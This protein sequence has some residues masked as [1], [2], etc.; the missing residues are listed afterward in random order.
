MKIENAKMWK[1]NN[2]INHNSKVWK[3]NK[4]QEIHKM[5]EN[6]HLNETETETQIQILLKWHQIRPEIRTFSPRFH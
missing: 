1:F 6:S 3:N 4:F 5:C 2:P